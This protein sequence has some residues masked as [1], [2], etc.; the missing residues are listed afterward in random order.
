MGG[1]GG[2]SE[3]IS[4]VLSILG[5]ELAPWMFPAFVAA[6]AVVMS[7]WLMQN[8]KTSRARTFLKESRVLDGD[9]RDAME[10]RALDTV[11]GSRHG[12]VAVVE[13]AH[14][15][16]RNALARKALVELRALTGATSEVARLA[17][18]TDPAPLPNSPA[19][20]GLMVEKLRKAG[21]D[22]KADQRLR[23]GLNRW[24]DDPWLQA[25]A[26]TAARRRMETTARPA[27]AATSPESPQK[28]AEGST[29]A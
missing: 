14:R 18:L 19:Q 22:D 23:R 13:E 2:I 3:A 9:A 4:G 11:S 12:L 6:L 27:E 10:A 25:L 5:I 1:M 16:R 20:L 8:M 7:P 24:P 28:G 15:M 17:R 29:P 21:L 26:G